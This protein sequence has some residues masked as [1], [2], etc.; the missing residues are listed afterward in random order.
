[1]CVSSKHPDLVDCSLEGVT[2]DIGSR[3]VFERRRGKAVITLRRGGC[4]GWYVSQ[5]HV[6]MGH[7][8]REIAWYADDAARSHRACDWW[9]ILLL[10][11]VW[12]NVAYPSQVHVVGLSDGILTH[13]R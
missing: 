4:T 3:S 12:G 7:V 10:G 8:V 5:G 9:E 13:L 2:W 6:T 1:M 11:A